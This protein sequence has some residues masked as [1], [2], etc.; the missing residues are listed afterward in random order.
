MRARAE[1]IWAS[2]RSGPTSATAPPRSIDGS[3]TTWTALARCPARLGRVARR[4][5]RPSGAPAVRPCH[6]RGP[7]PA[8]GS[9]AVS[10]QA[11]VVANF[12]ADD[13]LG[14][15]HGELQDLLLDVVHPSLVG[16]RR[17]DRAMRARAARRP[18][19]RRSPADVVR[20]R[21]PS[22]PSRRP[23]PVARASAIAPT[24]AV[25]R[26]MRPPPIDVSRGGS[27]RMA[28]A[29]TRDE[30]CCEQPGRRRLVLALGL[31]VQVCSDPLADDLRDTLWIGLG[32]VRS[33]GVGLVGG[34]LSIRPP[35]VRQIDDLSSD[36]RADA[37][38]PRW[39]RDG[40]SPRVGHRL[41]AHRPTARAGEGRCR[42]R[43]AGRNSTSMI[44]VVIDQHQDA[45][46]PAAV[47]EQ[48]ASEHRVHSDRSN[49]DCPPVIAPVVV[50]R[51]SRVH[52]HWH[53]LQ[54]VCRQL[55][56]AL[57]VTQ[58][59]V[60]P[61]GELGRASAASR[62]AAAN[63]GG[64]STRS[65]ISSSGRAVSRKSRCSSSEAAYE[66]ST[67]SHSGEGVVELI[68]SRT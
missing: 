62:R 25:D 9:A 31:P 63:I 35:T 37:Q 66:R 39:R 19:C 10:D 27:K 6:D 30:P 67:S 49:V 13:L 32:E 60:R 4:Q 45:R 58:Q 20:S 64:S 18:P 56:Q 1:L 55:R 48:I 33:E 61:R 47:V 5:R 11:V 53:A 36:R 42:W 8:R 14:Q 51:R 7:A 57:G 50:G 23:D 17:A 54:H 28:G 3:A 15:R 38:L 29:A 34:H 44:V 43:D 41:R 59:R 22:R 68:A 21:R 2:M 26:L 24:S 52:R 65:S 16:V 12:T 46:G 40:S